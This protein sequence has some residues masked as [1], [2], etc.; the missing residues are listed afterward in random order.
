MQ[1]IPMQLQRLEEVI[2][3]VFT[4]SETKLGVSN[5]VTQNALQAM[6]YLEGLKY[7]LTSILKSENN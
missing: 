3:K 2:D 5:T 1:D 7:D 4:G 6:L